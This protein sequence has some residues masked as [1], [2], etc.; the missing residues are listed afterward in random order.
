MKEPAYRRVHILNA[1][2]SECGKYRYKLTRL[3]GPRTGHV[4]PIIMLNPSTANHE[5]DD[6]TIRKCC[7]FADRAGFSGIAVY[8]LFAYRATK[9]RDL[10]VAADPRGPWNHRYLIEALEA[11]KVLV[12]WGSWGQRSL[13]AKQVEALLD[14]Y[15]GSA[16]LLC[17]DTTRNGDPVHP[18]MQSYDKKLRPWPP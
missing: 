18:L 11:S 17:I 9:P 7:V 5:V 14:L 3:W 6:P 2:L 10:L 4:L 16:E 15:D 13:V 12:A 1:D 8:N